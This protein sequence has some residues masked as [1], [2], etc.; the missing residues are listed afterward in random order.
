[1]GVDSTLLCFLSLYLLRSKSGIC[2]IRTGTWCKSCT[3]CRCFLCSDDGFLFGESCGDN[4][5]GIKILYIEKPSLY[6]EH[7]SKVSAHGQWS[8][9]LYAL[10]LFDDSLGLCGVCWQEFASIRIEH[11]IVFRCPAQRSQWNFSRRLC[12]GIYCGRYR[13]YFF[14]WHCTRISDVGIRRIALWTGSGY[15]FSRI[16]R[17]RWR[18]GIGRV[19]GIVSHPLSRVALSGWHHY[20]ISVGRSYCLAARYGII[21]T[22]HC[23]H[24]AIII[25]ERDLATIIDSVHYLLHT[26]IGSCRDGLTAIDQYSADRVLR[27]SGRQSLSA[28]CYRGYFGHIVF[29]VV[30]ID[31]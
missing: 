4:L 17:G 27:D 28:G 12:I 18:R 29:L 30:F 26:F 3:A 6:I 10:L 31:N 25:L 22:S 1:M 9:I 11:K 8:T 15:D 21:S 13:I 23:T 2:G 19:S 5:A 14:R 16:R 20:G 24:V 7:F